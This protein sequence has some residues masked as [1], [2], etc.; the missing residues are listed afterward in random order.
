MSEQRPP[1]IG[2][3]AVPSMASVGI[4]LLQQGV[5]SVV[6]FRFTAQHARQCAP[7]V[8]A[9]ATLPAHQR[10][11][12]PSYAARLVPLDVIPER[13][14]TAIWTPSVG[15]AR[16]PMAGGGCLPSRVAGCLA[17]SPRDREF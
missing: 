17:R 6:W 11:Y 4:E 2:F 8:R 5:R 3:P 15:P 14:S 1:P 7:Y 10:V 12:V 13:A 9:S 16:D